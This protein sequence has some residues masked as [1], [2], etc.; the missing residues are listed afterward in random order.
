MM[1]IFAGLCTWTVGTVVPVFYDGL[2][3]PPSKLP[4]CMG[5]LDSRLILGSLGLPESTFQ[6]AS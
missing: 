4:L 5:D 2:T 6:M 1:M 3:F